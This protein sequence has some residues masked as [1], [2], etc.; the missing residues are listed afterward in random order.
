MPGTPLGLLLFQ[1]V[2][3]VHRHRSRFK[4]EDCANSGTSLV[5][6]HATAVP[7]PQDGGW[8]PVPPAPA[9]AVAVDSERRDRGHG[10]RLPCVVA[11]EPVPTLGCAVPLECEHSGTPL[12]LQVL[13]TAEAV[14]TVTIA[15]DHRRPVRSIAPSVT[16]PEGG[17]PSCA[18]DLETML[19][20]ALRPALPSCDFRSL[21]TASFHEVAI[22]PFPWLPVVSPPR[23]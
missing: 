10:E 7:S 9:E 17:D 4:S 19:P 15:G 21:H 6:V 12:V 11:G 20:C 1:P 2:M 3:A 5:D 23:C 22:V 16:P 13:H 18:D 14:C 8:F